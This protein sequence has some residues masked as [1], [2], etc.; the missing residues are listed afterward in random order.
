VLLAL[1]LDGTLIDARAR[2]VGVARHVLAQLGAQPLREGRFWE[3]KRSGASTESALVR[4]GYTASVA[5]EGARLWRAEIEA[6]AWLAQ[7]QALP[8][9]EQALH[10]LRADGVSTAVL[11]ARGRPEGALSSARAAGLD[12]LIGELIVVSPERA[13]R[14]KASWLAARSP[15]AFIGD[16][17]SDG[18]AAAS[19]GVAFVAVA[20]GQRDGTYLGARGYRVRDTFAQAV[21]E[22]VGA[23]R[24]AST[25]GG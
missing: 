20:G 16:T 22:L 9:V 23:E 14:E 10:E 4:L 6:E 24:S 18:A 25:V 12:E 3:L 2:Q 19:A 13:S 8:G 5:G 21:A 11:T 1:D 15:A 7:D 17:E